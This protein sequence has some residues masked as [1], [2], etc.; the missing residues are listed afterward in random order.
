MFS[1]LFGAYVGIVLQS[2]TILDDS[3]LGVL[4]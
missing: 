4:I 2:L 3:C 1:M